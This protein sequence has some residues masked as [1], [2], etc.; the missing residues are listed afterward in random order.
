M[1]GGRQ[2]SSSL[3]N[4]REHL[5]GAQAVEYDGAFRG[6]HLNH[7]LTS[8]GIPVIANM[9]SGQHGT[10]PNRYYGPVTVTR[11][12]AAPPGASTTTTESPT[13]P[14]EAPFDSDWTAQP[15]T[16]PPV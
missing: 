9:H 1:L 2:A 4:R 11:G 15:R 14:A 13:T 6:V 7:L 16:S 12:P 3:P 10:V 8:H 5:P